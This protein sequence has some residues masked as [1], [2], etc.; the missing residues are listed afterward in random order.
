LTLNTR[1]SS[2]RDI[3]LLSLMCLAFPMYQGLAMS[4]APLRMAHMGLSEA[5]IGL[6]QAL[7][8]LM[9]LALGAPFA[10]MA[11]TR[12]RG[13]TLIVVF[14]MAGLSSLF[15]GQAETAVGF[16]VPQLLMGISTCAF[17]G[18]MLS[19]SFQ[20]VGGPAQGA[21]QGRITAFQGLGT[22]CG[23]LLGGSLLGFGPAW[24]FAPGVCC[25]L[26][27]AWCAARLSPSQ[28]LEPRP[29]MA[30]YLFGSYRRFL[31]VMTRRPVVV[32]GIALVALNSSIL[33]VMG[34]AFYLVYASGIGVSA[35][36]ATGLMSGRELVGVLVRFSFTPL[37][38]RFGALRLLVFSVVIGASALIFM[39]SVQSVFGMAVIAFIIGISGA[40]V[41]PALNLMVGGTAVR[42]EQSFAIL[43][44]ATGH[45][46]VQ[47]ITAP[48]LGVV[49]GKWGYSVSYPAMGVLWI[50]LA[51]LVLRVGERVLQRQT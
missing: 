3:H 14:C 29:H 9:V 30:R 10:Q 45:F 50:L 24:A 21:V 13:T 44:L 27:G 18:N 22:F 17:F 34:G 28:D 37:A 40:C 23:P 4:L 48:L 19:V 38:Q 15:F 33:Y 26:L 1:Q 11:N 41:P 49:L 42:H 36:L 51:L 46:C 47:T 7:P 43:C 5:T 32:L 25:A 35:V 20:L 12:W 39:P 6:V 8:G 2:G 16:I 31:R